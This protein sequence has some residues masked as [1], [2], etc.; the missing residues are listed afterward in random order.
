MT[1][2][3]NRLSLASLLADAPD[4]DN[5]GQVA[6]QG[7]QYQEWYAVLLVTELLEGAND[8]AVGLEIKDD[9]A[10]LD[11]STNPTRVE[12]C[13]V[14]T[15][16]QAVAWT[17]KELHRKGRK[18]KDG[19]YPP[20]ILGKLYKRRHDFKGHPTTLRFISNSS[21][22]VPVGANNANVNAHN[23]H[24]PS[25]AEKCKTELG[26]SLSSQ[27]SIAES[28]IDLA[29]IHLHRSNLPLADQHFF[30]SGKLSGLT[31]K[32]SLPFRVP[33]PVIAATMLAS[34][35]RAKA[36]NTGFCSKFDELKSARIFS[37][38]DALTLLAALSDPPKSLEDKFADAVER[39][40]YER[41]NYMVL[42]DIKKQLSSL[43]TAVA[44]R[45]NMLFRN[46]VLAL[47]HSK[48]EL[49]SLAILATTQLGTFT[50]AVAEKTRR[51]HPDDFATVDEPFLL[52]LSLMVIHNGINIDVLTAT[53]S[54]ESEVTK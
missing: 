24:L 12:F 2:A 18:L 4:D 30:I 19:T 43:L 54:P 9:I 41:Y 38:S 49:R 39:L 13:Q 27:L 37:R 10:V 28:D 35:V 31:S 48:N 42:E 14:K 6:A 40:N 53:A 45:T 1:S 47:E 7:F 16:E 33:Q 26:Q 17:I 8:F 44:D 22:K 50:D 11:S 3:Q 52:A 32:G 46:Q 25:L 34:E 21:F 5:S 15:N 36:S 29:E 23:L 20:S 51:E